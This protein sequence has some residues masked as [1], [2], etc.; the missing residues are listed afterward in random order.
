MVNQRE[1]DAAH[2]LSGR[3]RSASRTG[4]SEHSAAG[5]VHTLSEM[6]RTAAGEHSVAVAAH[7]LSE[8]TRSAA[9]EF[10]STDGNGR[11]LM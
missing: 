9:G 3:G 2:T 11:L 5:V 4:G 7:T 6:A 10:T 1:M 8:R